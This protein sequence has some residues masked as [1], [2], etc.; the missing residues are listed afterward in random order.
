MLS[1]AKGW[2]AASAL[3][4]VASAAQAT[5]IDFTDAD[6]W[7]ASGTPRTVSYGDLDVTLT[8]YNLFSQ[9][10]PFTNTP[11]DG[12]APC[13]DY[14]GQGLQ[15]ETDGIGI[16]DDE[17]TSSVELLK[18]VFSSAVDI[19]S[20]TLLDLFGSSP[21]DP[22][23]EQA[24]I[25]S[26]LNYLNYGIW[27]GIADNDHTGFLTATLDNALDSASAGLFTGVTS[28]FLGAHPFLGNPHNSDFALAAIELVDVP[29]PGTLLL[30]G[31]GL[32]SMLSL[33]R[34]VK[35]RA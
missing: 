33:R 31:M 4:V 14:G 23:A 26:D 32:L 28:L 15:C 21:D 5:L 29:E 20:I 22:I 24:T 9:Q 6:Q 18:V 12:Q 27:E 10:V 25:G 3:I 1:Y 30:F 8:A 13:A 19:K 34:I 16:G 11:Y 7:S 2:L 17:V 35:H